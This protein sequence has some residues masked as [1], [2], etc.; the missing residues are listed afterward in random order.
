MAICRLLFVSVLDDKTASHRFRVVKLLP[1]LT[2]LDIEADVFRFHPRLEMLALPRLAMHLLRHF[3]QPQIV[4]FQKTY[5]F[6]LA[7]LANRLGAHCLMDLDDGSMQRIDGSWYPDHDRSR[8]SKWFGR[9]DRV[10]VSCDELAE[11]VQQMGARST[12]VIPTCLDVESYVGLSRA[13]GDGTCRIGWV[14][15]TLIDAYL[16]PIED[17]LAAITS[18]H[19]C[20]LLIVGASEPR[21]GTDVRSQFMPWSLSIEPEVFSQFDIGIMPLPNNER[22]RMKAGFKLLQYMAAGLPVVA[23]P[24]GM[25][26]RIIRHGWNG[27]LANSPSEWHDAL[28]QLIDNSDLR[29]EMGENGRALVRQ[30]YSLSV[31]ASHWR[32]VCQQIVTPTLDAGNHALAPKQQ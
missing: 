24:I 19:N 25:N 31:A 14:G 9:M 7:N 12:S 13:D 4:V 22:A 18:S 26:A 5:A 28:S 17:S 6:A 8:R 23:S 16:Q 10:V 21:L 15:S 11:W 1:E 2:A 27:F 29:R 30:Q 32:N 3:G 20:E